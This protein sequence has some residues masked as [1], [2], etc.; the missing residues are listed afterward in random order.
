MLLIFKS[1]SAVVIKH[2][3][4][5]LGKGGWRRHQRQQKREE[6]LADKNSIK[7]IDKDF[8]SEQK[9]LCL[10]LFLRTKINSHDLLIWISGSAWGRA[11]L[12]LV[13]VGMT[14]NLTYSQSP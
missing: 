5:L 14:P 13:I 4:Y 7:T 11:W 1:S 12:A 10:C 3:N 2:G 6:L 8:G 9:K